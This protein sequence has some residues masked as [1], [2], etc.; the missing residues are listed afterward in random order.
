MVTENIQ[1]FSHRAV[2]FLLTRL[3]LVT[4]PRGRQGRLHLFCDLLAILIFGSMCGCDDAEALEEWAEKEEPWLRTFLS[5]PN[6]IPSQDTYLRALA[7]MDPTEFRA[8]FRGWAQ[9]ILSWLGLS[10]QVAIDGKEVRGART[11]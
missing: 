2:S 3:A 5:L 1:D 10:G 8:A 6:G 7:S 11:T 4:D 9:E